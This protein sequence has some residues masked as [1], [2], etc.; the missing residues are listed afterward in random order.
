MA[1]QES[2]ARLGLW[3]LLGAVL[4][5]LAYLI[6]GAAT[7]PAVVKNPAALPKPSGSQSAYSIS[8]LHRRL[9]PEAL[10]EVQRYL[11]FFTTKQRRRVEDG[12]A[13]SGRY[14]EAYRQIFRAEGIPEELVYLPMIESGFME[15]A[16]S[17]AKAVGVWQFIEETG[18]LYD[19]H[20]DDWSDRRRDPLGSARAAAKLL[21][22]LYDTFG[23]WDMA[24]AAYNSGAG[25]VKWAVKVNAKAKEP[26]QY[27]SLNLPEETRN[28]VPAFIAMVLIAK[29]PSAFGFTDIQFHAK[30]VF[31]QIKVSPGVSLAALGDSLGVDVDQLFELNPE[32]IRGEIPPGTQP[33]TLRVPVGTRGRVLHNLAGIQGGSNDYF[34][35]QVK[36]AD[37]LEMLAN[38]FP[39]R[40]ANIQRLNQI[41]DD[42]D[43]LGKR[44]LI[45][46]L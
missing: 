36:E 5:G 45:I 43:L 3:S 21:S 14:L 19:L 13:R 1:W 26:L 10:N 32:L 24:L 11:D 38:Q 8:A 29:N 17:P 31:D 15:N 18:K 33:Y 34:V 42:G 28:Y 22:H 46:P 12:L 20:H 37:T 16:V 25:T 40:F 6:A 44:Y 35:Y 7:I 2:L 39:S 27:W 30:I 4:V 23:D 9:P 41:K